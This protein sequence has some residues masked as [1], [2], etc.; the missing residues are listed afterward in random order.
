[1]RA[2]LP[3]A[4]LIPAG[5]AAQNG[6]MPRTE[7]VRVPGVVGLSVADGPPVLGD[8]RSIRG[9]IDRGRDNGALSR[10]DARDLDRQA[11]RI[12]RLAERWGEDGLSASEASTLQSQALVLRGMVTSRWNPARKD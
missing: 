8:V 4:L 2:L 1:M 5:A 9:T 6:W 11:R 12:G 10:R 3:L 7:T